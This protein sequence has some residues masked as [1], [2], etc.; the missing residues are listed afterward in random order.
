MSG[1][2]GMHSFL[3]EVGTKVSR[4]RQ[5][6]ATQAVLTMIILVHSFIHAKDESR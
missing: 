3:F 4:E 1:N 6:K 5:R 2:A